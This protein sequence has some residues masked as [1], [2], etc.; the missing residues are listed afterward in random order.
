M[1]EIRGTSLE[2]MTLAGAETSLGVKRRILYATLTKDFFAILSV[3]DQERS[4]RKDD[5]S[6]SGLVRGLAA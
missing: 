3:G 2:R 6:P 5:L 4:A 1:T